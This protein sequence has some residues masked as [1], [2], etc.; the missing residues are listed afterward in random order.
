MMVDFSLF[1]TASPENTENE[2]YFKNAGIAK[3]D[4]GNKL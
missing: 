3:H 4:F 2:S 1:S